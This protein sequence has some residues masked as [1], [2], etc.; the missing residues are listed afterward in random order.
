MM[1]DLGVNYAENAC[2]DLDENVQKRFK[3]LL[4]DFITEKISFENCCSSVEMLIGK[5][6]P[7]H[8]IK[9]II[10]LPEEPIPYH[11]DNDEEDAGSGSTRR[12]TR[13][14]T[15]AEDQRLLAG[16]YHYGLDNWQAVAQFLGSGRNRA[17][18]SQRWTRGLNPRISKKSWTEAEDKGC[19]KRFN[20]SRSYSAA[21]WILCE[22]DYS[23]RRFNES[24]I[25]G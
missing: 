14:W 15:I 8:R 17:Q 10:E 19:H 21:D 9:D 4:K 12:K 18:C 6:D 13:T 11:E 3:A 5:D 24:D 25:T 22:T 1:L 20:H 16:V 2:G 23:G 7:V